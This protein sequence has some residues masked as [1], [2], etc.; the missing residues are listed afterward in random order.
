MTLLS[1][2]QWVGRLP[3]TIDV[4]IL[5]VE[6]C[7][8]VVPLSDLNRAGFVSDVDDVETIRPTVGIVVVGYRVEFAVGKLVVH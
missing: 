8:R 6:A 2:P 5:I 4:Y 1:G 3:V 7:R